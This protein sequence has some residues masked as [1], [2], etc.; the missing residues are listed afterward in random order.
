MPAAN[1]NN[2]WRIQPKPV[3]VPYDKTAKIAARSL[4]SYKTQVPSP[5]DAR[6][7]KYRRRQS[8]LTSQGYFAAQNVP[9]KG[10]GDPFYLD[11]QRMILHALGQ[12]DAKYDEETSSS[13]DEDEYDISAELQQQKRQQVSATSFVLRR[14][15]TDMNTLQREV[16]HGRNMVRNV[17]LGHGLFDLIKTE[18]AAK[19]QSENEMNKMKA[20]Q[21]KNQWQ[22]PKLDSSSEESEE[23]IEDDV[24]LS[25]FMKHSDVRET[26]DDEE[27]KSEDESPDTRGRVSF[28]RQ[29]EDE[30]SELG[31]SRSLATTPRSPGRRKKIKA[32]RP[33]TPQH[34]NIME[35]K[36]NTAKDA[37]FRQLC[38]L[39]WILEAMALHARTGGDN[40][41]TMSP[42]TSSWKLNEIGGTKTY[43]RDHEGMTW[44]E[45]IHLEI[46]PKAPA[47]KRK[48]TRVGTI[49]R[50]PG[51]HRN[52]VFS[53]FL[54]M[55]NVSGSTNLRVSSSLDN[56]VDESLGSTSKVDGKEEEDDGKYVSIFKYLNEDISTKL[57]EDD[58]SQEPVGPVKV[59][60]ERK[61]R[62]KG[63]R[64]RTFTQEIPKKIS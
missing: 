8:Q 47:I 61:K 41:I 26:T 15:K 17:K 55:A 19:Q 16:I 37:F 5:H 1:R 42:I 33:Y 44:K 25:S 13:S 12:W 28:I 30:E 40:S 24:E 51:G 54:G 34:T 53:N 23:E 27:Q 52:S 43:P 9:Y 10:L 59:R 21:M 29:Q 32:P 56:S 22:P 35:A 11:E 63:S 62:K 4:A 48:S 3:P 39:H 31:V 46:S 57:Y 60:R 6:E 49:K 58:E 20:E 36:E 38:A 14:S 50:P 45:L 7:E 2:P 64:W 18:Q